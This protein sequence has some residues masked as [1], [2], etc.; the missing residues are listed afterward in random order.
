M[1]IPFSCGR[2]GQGG[3]GHQ[4]SD[5]PPFA[6]GKGAL[7][8]WRQGG[9]EVEGSPSNV[10]QAHTCGL[11]SRKTLHATTRHTACDN[12]PENLLQPLPVLARTD[13]SPHHRAGSPLWLL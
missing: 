4:I 11:I 13:I 1:T 9:R 3:R 7:G 12:S 8:Y 5:K 2:W 6:L 10:S